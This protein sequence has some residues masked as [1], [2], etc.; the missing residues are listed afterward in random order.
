MTGSFAN[1]PDTWATLLILIAAVAHAT[2]SALLKRAT[3]KVAAAVGMNIVGGIAFLPAAF[4]VPGLSLKGWLWVCGS[5]CV[6]ILYQRLALHSLSRGQLSTVYP[7]ARGTGP[8]VI[9]IMSFFLLPQPLT[10]L[11]FA[12]V[13][14]LVTGIF[15][16]SGLNPLH[17]FHQGKREAGVGSAMLTG[18]CIAAYTL[19]DGLA[20]KELGLSYIV[21][22]NLVFAPFF[23]LA[24]MKAR[25]VKPLLAAARADWK[26]G[27]LAGFIS[28][29]GYTITLFAFS[30]GG[31]GE[32]AALRETSILFAA[33]IGAFWLGESMS[34]RKI[35]ATFLIVSGALA[36]KL[37]G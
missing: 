24:A 4:M 23:V 5:V 9:G 13:L 7:I 19:I 36:I 10:P 25:P 16:M 3:D 12:G 35:L 30:L 22:V 32:I 1:H 15:T 18:L 20:V 27:L 21:W 33:L 26:T 11:Q 14:V 2:Y 29:G 34:R 28:Y 31:L 8:L 17:L 37:A 6:H